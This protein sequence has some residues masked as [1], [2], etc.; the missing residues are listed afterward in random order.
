MNKRYTAT[1]YLQPKDSQ[2][3]A[4]FAWSQ[5][6]PEIITYQ[7]WLVILEIFLQP[8]SVKDGYQIFQQIRQSDS[9]SKAIFSGNNY[10]RLI[11]D[12]QDPLVIIK[13]N[14]IKILPRGFRDFIEKSAQIE[15]ESLSLATHLVLSQLFEDYQITKDLE[16][17]D[18]QEKFNQ[19]VDKMQGLGLLSPEVNSLD[20]G[21]LKKTM[22]ICNTF[23]LTRGTPIDR[24]YLSKFIGEIRSE[25]TGEIIEIG[26]I[27]KDQDFYQIKSQNSYKI[28]NLEPGLGIDIV[29]DVHDSTVVESE[30]VDSIIIFNVLEHCY[31]PWIAVQNIYKWLKVGGKCFAMVPNAVRVHATPADYWRPLPDGIK[32]LFRDFSQQKLYVYGN[33]ITVIASYHGIATEELNQEELNTFHPDYPVATCIV[34]QK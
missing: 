23:G 6:P 14:S 24:Y 8:S 33:P 4:I 3:Y 26:G 32:Y 25:I 2:I 16:E 21:E 17:I 10:Q 22:P 12:S 9:N 34:A 13:E 27:P 7:S 19:I 30:S 1:A 29:G 20:W 5:K 11:R 31:A 28:L 15:L 18:S